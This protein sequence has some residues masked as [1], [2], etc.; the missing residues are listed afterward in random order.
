[1]GPV[2]SRL[3]SWRVVTMKDRAEK[4]PLASVPELG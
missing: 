2:E 1:M 3:E 4:V